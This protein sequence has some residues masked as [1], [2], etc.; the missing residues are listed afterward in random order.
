MSQTTPQHLGC[1]PRLT[2]NSPTVSWPPVAGH[3]KGSK[4]V[5]KWEQAFSAHGG[6]AWETN[7]RN[8]L[9]L[10]DHCRPTVPQR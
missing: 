5:A 1:R 3:P 10:D 6:K 8:E 4:V 7:W 2:I 9:M